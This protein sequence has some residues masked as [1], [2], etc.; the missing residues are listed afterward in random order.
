MTPTPHRPGAEV[1]PLFTAVGYPGQEID[2][3]PSA[4]YLTAEQCAIGAVGQPDS[5]PRKT[6]HRRTRQ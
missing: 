1:R 2:K 3:A 4:G 6:P 5:L